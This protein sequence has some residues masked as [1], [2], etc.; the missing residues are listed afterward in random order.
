M[1]RI[2]TT[3]LSIFGLGC[4]VFIGFSSCKTTRVATTSTEVV[5][6]IG[7]NKLI[8]NI[9]NNAFDYKHLSIKRITCQFDNG[10]TKTSFKASI[11][12][13]KDKQIIV[14]LSKLN[15]PVGRLWLTPDSVK[16][17]NYLENNYFLDDYSYLSS[18]LDM[19]LDFETV[20]AIVSNNIFSLGAE[21]HDKEIKDYA[22]KIDS[23]MYVLESV[24]KLKPRKEIQR[25]S[26]RRQVRN[27]QKIVP[28]S[29]VRQSIYIDPVT[30][31]LRKIKLIDATNARDLNIDFSDFVPVDK[32]IYPGEMSLRFDSPEST[33]QLHIKFAGF[34]TEEEKD[35]RFRVPEKY[36][37]I[38]H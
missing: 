25:M 31:K 26:E 6:P 18:M 35:I 22:A 4:L 17:I 27:A 36:T 13:K 20:H 14:M 30:F 32:Q 10:K 15:I 29:P 33:M 23:G 19:D 2:Q 28:D 7:T 8:R 1:V 3:R 21:K 9:E 38:N 37:R 24:K 5:K 11:V 34:S 12:A 16:F